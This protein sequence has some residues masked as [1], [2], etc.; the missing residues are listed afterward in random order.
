MTPSVCARAKKSPRMAIRGLSTNAISDSR[1]LFRLRRRAT[2]KKA[3]RDDLRRNALTDLRGVHR[4]ELARRDDAQV[5]LGF[6]LNLAPHADEL[7]DHRRELVVVASQ[8]DDR[9]AVRGVGQAVER[10]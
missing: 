3:R 6:V 5:E 2:R 8:V 9:P 1:E 4:L 7:A 10:L